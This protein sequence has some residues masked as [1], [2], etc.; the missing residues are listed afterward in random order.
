[1]MDCKKALDETKDI[2]KAID[3]LRKKGI[4]TAQKNQKDRLLMVL[5]L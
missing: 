3:W 1:M 5:L 4:N 2:D